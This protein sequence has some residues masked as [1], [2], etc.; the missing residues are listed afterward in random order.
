PESI[1]K[2]IAALEHGT[3]DAVANP[4]LATKAVLEAGDGLEP[5]LTAAEVRRTLP[6]LVPQLNGEPFGYMDPGE[7]AAFAAFMAERGL[8]KTSANADQALTN[9][10]LPAG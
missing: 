9:E 10:L 3:R 8:I 6:L 5:K 2:F 4:A 1:R 7:W